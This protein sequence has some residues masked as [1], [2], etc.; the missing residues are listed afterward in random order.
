MLSYGRRQR[1]AG[2]ASASAAGPE[3][4]VQSS[5]F[6]HRCTVAYASR[7]YWFSVARIIARRTEYMRDAFASVRG[8][9]S[10]GRV[11]P[12][13]RNFIERIKSAV[14]CIGSSYPHFYAKTWI[15]RNH[16]D[17]GR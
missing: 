16:D 4:R 11:W 17:N 2:S 3:F 9:S 6:L 14:D 15:W 7:A 12:E 1:D 10:I 8:D 5:R 13:K